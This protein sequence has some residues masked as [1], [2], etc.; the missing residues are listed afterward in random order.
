MRDHRKLIAVER[1]PGAGGNKCQKQLSPSPSAEGREGMGERGRGEG[2]G[3]KGRRHGE[4]AWGGER[5]RG[6]EER[7]AMVGLRD[8]RAF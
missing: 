2:R 5:R 4:E 3:E 1:A 6:G 7:R 8:I